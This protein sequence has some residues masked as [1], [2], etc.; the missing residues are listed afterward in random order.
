MQ[1]EMNALRW[2]NDML[3]SARNRKNESWRINNRV[4][5]KKNVRP[6]L[7]PDLNSRAFE[8][9]WQKEVLLQLGSRNLLP[10]HIAVRFFLSRFQR[11]LA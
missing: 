5:L 1:K 8:Q 9:E 10:F 4:S 3:R 2:E 6:L 7:Y 11:R